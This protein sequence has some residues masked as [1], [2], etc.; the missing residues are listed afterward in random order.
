MEAIHPTPFYENYDIPTTNV[1]QL[2]FDD[3]WYPCPFFNTSSYHQ[4][5][6]CGREEEA[7]HFTSSLWNENG[8]IDE[9]YEREEPP[10]NGYGS[11]LRECNSVFSDC[12]GDNYVSLG[13]GF[14]NNE[15]EG[16]DSRTLVVSNP[17]EE[18][19]RYEDT[20]NHPASDY[21][22][23]SCY[24]SLFHH[25]GEKDPSNDYGE[26][27]EATNSH[28]GLPGIEVFEGIFGYWPC[29]YR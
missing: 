22:S 15:H 17:S 18:Q 14:H 26:E 4:D 12:W 10:S 9:T 23:W 2:P 27:A 7:D 6:F 8:D 11:W 28:H 19:G 16:G 13:N 1:D 5:E 29:L 25:G 24:D 3:S 20:E 21:A